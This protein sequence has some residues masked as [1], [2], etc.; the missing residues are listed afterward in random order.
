MKIGT[1]ELIIW[2]H[3]S[4]N[5][6]FVVWSD[7]AI[8][9][10]LSNY[11]SATQFWMQRMGW[12]RGGR[13]RIR[14][15]RCVRSHCLVRSRQWHI[16]RHSTWSTRGTG[17]RQ[18]MTWPGTP[19]PTNEHQNLCSASSTRLWTMHMSCTESWCWEMVGKFYGKGSEGAGTW[20]VPM[21]TVNAIVWDHLHDMDWVDGHDKGTKI[22]NDRKSEVMLSPPTSTA[23][24]SAKSQLTD[25]K[26]RQM[27]RVH[28]PMHTNECRRCCWTRCPGIKKSKQNKSEH[29]IWATSVRN[30]VQT[31][32]ARFVCATPLKRA[33]G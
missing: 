15:G 6:L 28:Q 24:I 16:A 30:A 3:I 2:E 23:A 19:G 32:G 27:W 26:K 1:Y 31:Q 25:Q 11:H 33:K 13:T 9:K 10:T 7:N 14:S 21:R 17:R 20:F 4:K 5:L 8:M 29:T 18:S 22:R 12:G